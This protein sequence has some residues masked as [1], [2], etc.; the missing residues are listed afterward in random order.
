MAKRRN[1]HLEE[2][3]QMVW[4]EF[5]TFIMVTYPERNWILVMDKLTGESMDCSLQEMIEIMNR[6]AADKRKTKDA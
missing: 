5:K 2:E 6:I 4:L 3:L 1:P